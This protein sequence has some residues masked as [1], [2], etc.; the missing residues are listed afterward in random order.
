MSDRS[1][2]MLLLAMNK[3]LAD[4]FNINNNRKRKIETID[5]DDVSTD[6]D[7]EPYTK[8]RQVL[9]KYYKNIFSFIIMNI[10]I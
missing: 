2:E 10:L 9:G 1:K 6:P 4:K 7:Y 8:S 3:Q 5:N